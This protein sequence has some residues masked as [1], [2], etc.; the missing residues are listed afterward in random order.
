MRKNASWT[1]GI[2]AGSAKELE[3]YITELT[4]NDFQLELLESF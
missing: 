4:P 3:S 1:E 2:A